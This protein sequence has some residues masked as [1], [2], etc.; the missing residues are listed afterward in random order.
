LDN[1]ERAPPLVILGLD[2]GDAAFIQRWASQGHLPTIAAIMARGCWGTTGGPELAIEHGI[3]PILFGGRSRGELGYYYF[4]QLTPGSYDLE[5]VD[6]VRLG[7]VPFWAHLPASL[8]VLVVDAPDV[9]LVSGRPGVQLLNWGPNDATLRPRSVPANLL[10][11]V[12]RRFPPPRVAE[13]LN[14]TPARDRRILA[15]LRQRVRTRGALC[16]HLLSEGRFDLAVIVF[17]E[18]HLAGH[19]FWRYHREQP[20][21]RPPEAALQSAI[22][23]V[24]RD[25]DAELG[26]LLAALPAHANVFVL[27]SIGMQGSYPTGGLMEAFC[28]A[29]GYQAA[30]APAPL[31]LRP[32]PLARRVLPERWRVALSRRLP[33][34]T[35]E[36]L[37]ADQFRA[38]ADWRR[39]SAFTIPT[40]FTSVLFANL[41]GRQP[42]GVVQ[43]GADCDA[44]LD[45]LESDLAQLVDPE[46]GTPAVARVTRSATAFAGDRGARLPDLFVSWAPRPYFQ[47]RV[48][49]PRAELRQIRPDFFRD[50]DHSTEGFL[51]AA[52]PA[53]RARGQVGTLSPLDVAP[54]FLSLLGSA[55]PP[56]W[57]GRPLVSLLGD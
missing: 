48:L 35:R 11:D 36:R 38:S 42:N 57:P 41:V 5:L 17:P 24:Y 30:A 39:T 37:L 52:G 43:P 7:A 55:I 2:D 15:G 9:P 31:S 6:G 16:R 51:A 46:A 28:R 10:E 18:S 4:R 21:G 44:L 56:T 26:R 1:E 8:Q 53:I 32:L 29:L 12:Q 19:Q 27:S 47:R 25:I 50:S 13:D 34:L 22:L 3:W 49:H 33:R 14:S 54:T 20:A 40:P 45:R 23:E